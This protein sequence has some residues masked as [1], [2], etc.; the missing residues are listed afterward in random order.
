LKHWCPR[1]GFCLKKILAHNLYSVHK[2]CPKCGIIYTTWGTGVYICET[3]ALHV[4]LPLVFIEAV[5]VH[6][7]RMIPGPQHR[8]LL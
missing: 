2:A 4:P 7:R 8:G 3:P 5:E 1:D 6:F